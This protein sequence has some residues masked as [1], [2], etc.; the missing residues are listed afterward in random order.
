MLRTYAAPRRQRSSGGLGDSP[1]LT[2][3]D[4]D[5]SAAEAA[6]ASA[7]AGDEKQVAVAAAGTGFGLGLNAL[8]PATKDFEAAGTSAVTASASAS[9]HDD[10]EG[11]TPAAGGQQAITPLSGPAPQKVAPMP[12]ASKQAVPVGSLPAGGHMRARFA[13][14]IEL[15]D[16]KIASQRNYDCFDP[17]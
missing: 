9:D 7:S 15:R 16:G 1:A 10:G 6:A 2:A 8:S 17:Y 12:H 3:A 13:V 5:P 14:F 11:K 4:Q